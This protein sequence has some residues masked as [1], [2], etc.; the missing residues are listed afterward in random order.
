[1]ATILSIRGGGGG[2]REGG[3]QKTRANPVCFTKNWVEIGVFPNATLTSKIWKKLSVDQ[4][5]QR[6]RSVVGGAG[7][8]FQ[9]RPKKTKIH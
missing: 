6:R 7:R 2:G 4:K 1:M 5:D 3:G 9:N 8:F